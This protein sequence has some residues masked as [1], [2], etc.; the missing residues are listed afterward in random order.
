M[1]VRYVYLTMLSFLLITLLIV[2][3][4]RIQENTR[5][6]EVNT[7]GLCAHEIVEP[8]PIPTPEPTPIY[9]TE[10]DVYILAQAMVGECYGHEY[11]DMINV[12][13]TICNRVDSPGFPDTIAEV[14]KQPSQIHGYSPYN[15]PSDVHLQAA[16]E[17]LDNWNAIK[18]GEDRPWNYSYLFWS[19]SGGTTN[20]FRSEY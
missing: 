13:I 9:Y 16:T 18:N 20:I 3:S 17:V 11:Q 12:G 8:T 5:P 7:E 4:I 6:P 10:D 2:I 15:I 19:A 1:K 14:I